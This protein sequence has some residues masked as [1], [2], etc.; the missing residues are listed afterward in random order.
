MILIA[1]FVAYL[2]KLFNVLNETDILYLLFDCMNRLYTYLLINMRNHHERSRKSQWYGLDVNFCSFV[3]GVFLTSIYFCY[4]AE[5][6]IEYKITVEKIGKK[7]KYSNYF[8]YSDFLS[9]M[10]VLIVVYLIETYRQSKVKQQK[11]PV[12]LYD[13]HTRLF[14]VRPHDQAATYR[15]MKNFGRL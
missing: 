1:Y 11:K 5:P 4:I 9:V 2:K 15:E 14:L 10:L 7:L 13:D 6:T 3:L 12:E 8:S